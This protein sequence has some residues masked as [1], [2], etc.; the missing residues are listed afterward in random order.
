MKSKGGDGMASGR[1]LRTDTGTVV[2]H[3]VLVVA[4]LVAGVTGLRIAADD[5]DFAWLNALDSLLPTDNL[6]LNHMLAAVVLVAVMVAYAV[7]VRATGLTRRITLDGRLRGIFVGGR[8]AAQ[9]VN[10]VLLW[11]FF[12]AMLALAVSGVTLYLAPGHLVLAIHLYAA[13]VALV[14][15]LL[16]VLTHVRIGGL[17]QCLRIIRPTA[18]IPTPPP[19]LAELFSEHLEREARDRARRESPPARPAT[20][21]AHPLATAA[22]AALTALALSGMVECTTRTRLV[23]KAITQADAPILDGDLADPVWAT[24]E[25]VQVMTT[26]GFNFGA[27]RESLVEI[28]AVHDHEYAYFAFVWQDPTR[29][30]KHLPLLKHG[31][32]WYLAHDRYDLADET[33]YHEDKFAVLLLRADVT[34][35]GAA[36]HLTHS[37]IDGLPASLPGR[38][39]HYTRAGLG[40]MWQWKA[41]EGGLIGYM[42]NEHFGT[43][44]RPS[45]S[46]ADGRE[47]YAGGFAPDAGRAMA[48]DNFDPRPPG[49]FAKPVTPHRLPR[50]LPAMRAALGRVEPD[51]DV[52]EGEGS[53]WWMSE[54]ESVPYSAEA[55]A[56]IPDGTVIP[57]VIIAGEPTGGRAEIRC[58]AKWAAGRWTLEVRRKLDTGRPEDVAIRSDTLMW[59]AAF[60]HAQTRHTRH[61]RPIRLEVE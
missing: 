47:R 36:I 46:Q 40:D 34:M 48:A 14:F 42:D 8:T 51:G 59:V 15:P 44:A 35:I 54:A 3:L 5:P 9:A 30:L 60:D 53:R 21:N 41:T 2:L 27:N 13:G 24:A 26:Q 29:S 19:S 6:W 32:V 52:G 22:A 16:H 18:Q 33:T 39:L 10:A 7:Y 43:A 1:T 25:P 23:V 28:R 20:L 57:G 55:D 49:G 12:L 61:L 56:A 31:G 38:G 45:A 4:F 58:A 17:A 11:A 50:D 37:A